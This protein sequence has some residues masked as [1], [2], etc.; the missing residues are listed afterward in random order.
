MMWS[1]AQGLEELPDLPSPADM[2]VGMV[3]PSFDLEVP[4]IILGWAETS[5]L[6]R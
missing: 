3:S 6:Q 1:G 5:S 2:S 4:N